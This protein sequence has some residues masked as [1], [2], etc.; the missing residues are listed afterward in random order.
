M[1]SNDIKNICL[2]QKRLIA[3]FICMHCPWFR[4]RGDYVRV[5]FRILSQKLKHF[6]I[7]IHSLY[8][9]KCTNVYLKL[10]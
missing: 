4:L 7:E 8:R 1:Q 5:W 6:H 3:L 10:V 9:T 2:G